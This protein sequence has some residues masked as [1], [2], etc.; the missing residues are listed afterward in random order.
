MSAA[1]ARRQLEQCFA[2]T[3]TAD[4]FALSQ[5]V[6][7]AETVNQ[8]AERVSNALDI[9]NFNGHINWAY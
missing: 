3:A 5:T 2:T 6:Q 9:Q 7:R 4:G 8:Q 1:G